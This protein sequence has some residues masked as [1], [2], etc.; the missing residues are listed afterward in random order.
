MSK[1]TIKNPSSPV[2]FAQ[3][4][5]LG[6]LLNKRASDALKVKL[7][8]AYQE[9]FAKCTNEDAQRKVATMRGASLLF[10]Y[11]S[12]SLFKNTGEASASIKALL[13][14]EKFMPKIS[15]AD[16]KKAATTSVEIYNI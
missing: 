15:V 12:Y 1:Y 10:I 14:D 6:G 16:L 7:T 9:A 13:A 3:A 4:N 2:T 11:A 8:E 5:Y